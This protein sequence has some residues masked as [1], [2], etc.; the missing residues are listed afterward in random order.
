MQGALSTPTLTETLPRG[1]GRKGRGPRKQLRTP[2]HATR[3]RRLTCQR[4][5]G[6]P[7]SLCTH[8]TV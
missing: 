3:L 1:E 7:E 5:P 8:T 2:A 4:L 6:F